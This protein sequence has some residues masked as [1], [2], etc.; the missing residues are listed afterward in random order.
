MTTHF[1]DN[2]ARRDDVKKAGRF[3]R[4]I[5]LE[6]LLD[7]LGYDSVVSTALQSVRQRMAMK[8]ALQDSVQVASVSQVAEAWV[9]VLLSPNIMRQGQ[10]RRKLECTLASS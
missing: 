6:H 2:V 4:D 7:R 8:D 1:C 9:V 3:T 5:L 10:P